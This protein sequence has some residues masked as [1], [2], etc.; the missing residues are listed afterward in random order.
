MRK[1]P[2]TN[3]PHFFFYF[4][5]GGCPVFTRGISP[6]IFFYSSV[7]DYRVMFKIWGLKSLAWAKVLMSSLPVFLVTYA[8]NVKHW[9][10]WSHRNDGLAE[11]RVNDLM[12]FE[13]VTSKN[14]ENL[15]KSYG[16]EVLWRK[17]RAFKVGKAHHQN[18]WDL[19]WTF[20]LLFRFIWALLLWNP[21]R[22]VPLQ[23]LGRS[24]VMLPYWHH[25]TMHHVSERANK[26]NP[27][28]HSQWLGSELYNH[29]SPRSGRILS[30]PKSRCLQCFKKD[31]PSMHLHWRMQLHA[32]SLIPCGPSWQPSCDCS[33]EWQR[34]LVR[35]ILP[36]ARFAKQLPLIYGL[37]FL[38]DHVTTW[39]FLPLRKH[40]WQI[41][42]MANMIKYVYYCI[43]VYTRIFQS[44]QETVGP[45]WAK[46]TFED[47]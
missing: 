15:P 35:C 39:R 36:Y 10:L 20:S 26:R 21:L 24:P 25:T 31:L 8:I 29:R 44:P 38:P 32:T 7:G 46:R 2:G 9:E 47:S 27:I 45:T 5:F 3:S 16:M 1:Y 28:H 34:H 30:G 41:R 14:G 40:C 43:P 11:V 4:S 17:A 42:S 33:P 6:F 12:R 37:F 13:F 19:N 18:K 22:S 23:K